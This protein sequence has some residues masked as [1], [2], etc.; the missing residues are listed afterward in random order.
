MNSHRH[1]A[2]FSRRSDWRKN[3]R[4]SASIVPRKWLLV[5]A[6][7][8]II[9]FISFLFLSPPVVSSWEILKTNQVRPQQRLLGGVVK[10]LWKEIT[11]PHW[12]A[13]DSRWNRYVVSLVSSVTAVICRPSSCTNS[14]AWLFQVPAVSIAT[15]TKMWLLTSCLYWIPC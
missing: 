3:E 11:F 14:T 13:T 5:R 8:F 6:E 1:W 7:W 4:N 12:R 2:T 10:V 9:V 15:A